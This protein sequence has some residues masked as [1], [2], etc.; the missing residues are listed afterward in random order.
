MSADNIARPS[1]SSESWSGVP[2]SAPLEMNSETKIRT[3]HL[4]E[5]Q[6][7]LEVLRLEERWIAPRATTAGAA[8]PPQTNCGWRPVLSHRLVLQ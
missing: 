3:R 8:D 2:D 5:R 4:V 6:T 1:R 7:R